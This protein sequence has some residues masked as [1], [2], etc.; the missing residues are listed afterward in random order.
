MITLHGNQLRNL[1][2]QVLKNKE[3]IAKHYQA[4]QLPANLAGITVIGKIDAPAEL[5]GVIGENYGDAYVQVVGDDTILW[6]WTRNNPDAGENND[7][8][9][10]IPFTTVGPMGPAGKE[11]KEGKQGVRGS[12]WFSGT[13]Q[14]TTTSGYNIGDYYINVGTGNIWH[15]HDVN[16]VPAWLLEGNILGPQ[17]PQGEQGPVGPAGESGPIGPAG[18]SGPAGPIV[19]VMG[20][21]TSIDQLPDPTTVARQSAYLLQSGDTYNVYI[22]IGEEGNESW[23][24]AGLFA[25]GTIVTVDGSPV[26]SFDA[27][28]KLNK[29]TGRNQIYINNND[30]NPSY[31]SWST[32]PTG[33]T[34]PMRISSGDLAVP[35]TPGE[36]NFAASKAYVD[37]RIPFPTEV[38]TGV[39]TMLYLPKGTSQTTGRVVF[40][41]GTTGDS[42]VRRT[43]EGHIQVKQIPKG[44]NINYAVGYNQILDMLSLASNMTSVRLEPHDY[45]DPVASSGSYGVYVILGGS[46]LR[47][48]YSTWEDADGPEGSGNDIYKTVV[49][50]IHFIWYCE[51]EQGQPTLVHLYQGANGFETYFPEYDLAMENIVVENGSTPG[52]V[53]QIRHNNPRT[54]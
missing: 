26:Q 21:I 47:V 12:Q 19:D 54:M 30:G 34:I 16:T 15:L 4:T 33:G 40:T 18:P 14:P 25:A 11:G 32:S 53:I 43:G 27:N 9:L 38:I 29:L 35:L 28:T 41:S 44:T 39:D 48:M 24:N 6:I 10:D 20:T 8:W 50:P 13:G 45:Y 2:E 36:N 23:F 31:L 52:R 17:G 49:S 1:E 51:D 3:D 37:K 46:D 5:E 22:I 7:Y 42:A